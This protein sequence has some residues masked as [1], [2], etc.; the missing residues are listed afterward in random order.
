M[1]PEQDELAFKEFNLKVTYANA[2]HTPLIPAKP[3]FRGLASAT[4]PMHPEGE[5]GTSMKSTSDTLNVTAV[6]QTKHNRFV[7][8]ENGNKQESARNTLEI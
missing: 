5:L 2:T 8:T 6:V 4:L 7:T 3:N 1:P